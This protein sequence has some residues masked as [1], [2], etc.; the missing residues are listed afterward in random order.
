MPPSKTSNEVGEDPHF[1]TLAKAPEASMTPNHNLQNKA[2]GTASISSPKPAAAA[3]SRTPPVTTKAVP[4]SIEAASKDWVKFGSKLRHQLPESDD[5]NGGE[6][7]P[8]KRVELGPGFAPE[9]DHQFDGRHNREDTP[10]GPVNDHRNPYIN[11]SRQDRTSEP[12]NPGNTPH[13]RWETISVHTAKCDGCGNHNNKVVQRCKRCNLQ[14]CQPCLRTRNDG[15]HFANV[16][17]LDWTPKPMIR[18]KRT[19]DET[20]KRKAAPRAA[21]SKATKYIAFIIWFVTMLTHLCPGNPHVL[22]PVLRPDLRVRGCNWRKLV[23]EALSQPMIKQWTQC[24]MKS[25]V[26]VNVLMILNWIMMLP[27]SVITV[28]MKLWIGCRRNLGVAMQLIA[29]MLMRRVQEKSQLKLESDIRMTTDVLGIRMRRR[30][31]NDLHPDIAMSTS[32]LIQWALLLLLWLVP[33]HASFQRP[34]HALLL[35]LDVLLI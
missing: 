27:E 6:A 4:S 8:K 1:S 13:D 30:R 3:L 32:V 21:A 9:H 28:M 2:A 33:D 35:G 10:N 5:E 24:L 29:S 19:N 31:L 14:Y 23:D 34:A 17:A 15:V 25:P 20:K 11:Q 22:R 18:S 12:H 26:I 16:D 7:S